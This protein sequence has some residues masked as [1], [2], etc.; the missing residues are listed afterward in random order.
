MEQR[1][2]FI[3]VGEH[4]IAYAAVG[5]GPPLVLPAQWISDLVGDWSDPGFR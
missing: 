2:G 4:R 5:T 3:R 1:T